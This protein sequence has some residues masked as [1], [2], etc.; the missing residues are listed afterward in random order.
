[1][2]L[3]DPLQGGLEKGSA[4]SMEYTTRIDEKDPDE[5]HV[6]YQCPC[7][8]T[9]G[10]MYHRQSGSEH[11]GQCCC[12]R[13]LWLGDDAEAVVTSSFDADIE[14]DLETNRVTLPWG[15]TATAVLAVP[16]RS[17][18]LKGSDAGHG[19]EHEH[20]G[21]EHSHDHEHRDHDAAHHDHEHHDDGH[22]H[23]ERPRV[24]D[25]VCGM[26]IDPS[27][28]A[29]TS[30]YKGETYYFCAQTCKQQFDADPTRYVKSTS[31]LGRILGRS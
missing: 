23:V 30:V 7:G 19:Q 9:A 29:A 20:E 15:D 24:K 12:G 31:L 27:T 6:N 16:L 3:T 4:G 2:L 13:L 26:M 21:H 14:Y 25:L 8:C 28:A 17:L 10:L 18:N 5:A 22:V 11:L 1:M